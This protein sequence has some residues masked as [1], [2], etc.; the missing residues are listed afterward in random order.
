MAPIKKVG[1]FLGACGFLCGLIAYQKYQVKLDTAAA[2]A[3]MLNLELVSVPIP[4]ETFVAAFFCVMLVVAS[5]SCLL[6]RE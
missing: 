4:I 6:S 1:M 2:V 3:E 5:G